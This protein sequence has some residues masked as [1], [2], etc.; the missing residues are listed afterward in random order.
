VS[1][2]RRVRRSVNAGK[3]RANLA[4]AAREAP[5]RVLFGAGYGDGHHVQPIA[6]GRTLFAVLVPPA[7]ASDTLLHAYSARATASLTGKCPECGA[8]RHLRAGHHG[9]QRARY[10][11]EPDCS[12]SDEAIIAALRERAA[13]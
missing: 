11:H 6:V 3:L 1:A 10:E 13:S 8:R 7:G 12:A 2:G 9:E 4:E 5:Q